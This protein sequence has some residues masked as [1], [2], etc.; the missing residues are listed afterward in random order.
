MTAL[1][2]LKAGRG[3]IPMQ[4]QWSRCD[5]AMLSCHGHVPCLCVSLPWAWS[6]L[7]CPGVCSATGTEDTQ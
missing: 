5:H 2:W 4:D 7:M 1:R 3:A 6:H